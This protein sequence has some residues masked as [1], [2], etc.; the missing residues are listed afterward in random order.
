MVEHFP[1]SRRARKNIA[2]INLQAF[3]QRIASPDANPR[4]LAER[5]R[6]GFAYGGVTEN[7]QQ[8]VVLLYQQQ[9]EHP[10]LQAR[11]AE[12]GKSTD[13]PPTLAEA[14]GTAAAVNHDLPA[15][16]STCMAVAQDPKSAVSWNNL[17]YVLVQTP[18]P[19]LNTA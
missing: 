14:L 9:A 13:L 1:K 2:A 10:N 17:A 8:R 3:D 12:L 18:N 11:F 15:C 19:P 4:E 6:T 16:K 5:L 7:M